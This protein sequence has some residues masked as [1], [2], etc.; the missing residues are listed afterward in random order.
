MTMEVPA[1]LERLLSIMVQEAAQA[2]SEIIEPIHLFVAALKSDDERVVAAFESLGLDHVHVRRRARGIARQL[3]GG[4]ERV[5]QR[6]V[7]PRVTEVV[8]RVVGEPDAQGRGAPGVASV[9]IALLDQ[10]DELVRVLIGEVSLPVGNIL[11]ALRGQAPAVGGRVAAGGAAGAAG[12]AGEA[13]RARVARAHP[14]TPLLDRFGRDF[15]ALARAGRLPKV[16]GR[17][18][19]TKQVARILLRKEKSNPIL[20]GDPGVGKTSIVEGLAARA[21]APDAPPQIARLRVVELVLTALVS[22]TKLRGELEERVEKILVEAASDRDLVL[23]I[24]E[25]H[26]VIGAGDSAGGMTV[27]NMLKPALARGAI[28]C[29]AATTQGEFKRF[30]EKDPALERRFQPVRVEEPTPA[31]AREMLVGL[32][33]GYEAHHEVTIGEDA[34]DAAV[35]LSVR[36]LPDRRLPDKARDLLD[37]AAANKRLL[38][39]S[40]QGEGAPQG[41][42]PAIGREDVAAVVGDWTRIPVERLTA[43]SR[44]WLGGLEEALRARVVG[45][46]PAIATLADVVRPALTGLSHP[47]RPYGVLLFVGPTGVGKTELAKALAEFLFG[48]EKHLLRFDMSEYMDQHAVSGLIG[49]PPGYI[50]HGDGG[51]LTD[52]VRRAPYGV[53]LLDEIEKAHPRV[54]DLFLQVF[55]EGRL[56]DTQGRVADFR[57]TFIVMTSNLAISGGRPRLPVG[58]NVEGAQGGEGPGSDELRRELARHLRPE[59][60]QRI[61]RVVRFSALDASHVRSIIDKLLRGV[62]RRLSGE[63]VELT[64]SEGAYEALIELAQRPELGARAME[65]AIEA[66]VVEPIAAA[67]VDGRLTAGPVELTADAAGRLG[68]KG[69]ARDQ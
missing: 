67:L 24:D 43:H 17:G 59:L 60:V 8:A 15:T 22:G 41:E 28:R 48:S 34:I 56:T 51:K 40:P 57:H 36:Y 66:Q 10:P 6:G 39:F 23:F 1:S 14:A 63:G 68:F 49:A 42:R 44:A 46:E 7:S 58:F 55:D 31:E 19:E 65:R 61:G 5:Q 18:D 69:R 4:G 54:F 30:V 3:T 16:I 21:A 53:V 32:R 45:Q 38:T 2:R 52:A 62:Q 64:I 12:A 27:G 47:G 25:F 33:P 9:L 29:I 26:T 35:E 20:L 11:A 37:Q 50:G 13:E